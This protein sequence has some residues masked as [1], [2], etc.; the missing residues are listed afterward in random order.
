MKSLSAKLSAICCIFAVAAAFGSSLYAANG[1]AETLEADVVV[2][3]GGSAGFAAAWSA[4]TL[5]SRVILVEKEK[6]LGGTSTLGGVNSWEPVCGATGV[7]RR[8]YARLS[9]MP[10][11]AGVYEFVHHGAWRREGELAFPGAL[12]RVNPA[13]PYEVTLRRHG[14]GIGDEKWFR[15]NCHGVIFEPLAMASVMED[16]LREAGRCQMLLGVACADVVRDGSRVN[17]LVLSDGR[18][19]RA[20]VVVDACGVVCAKMGCELMSGREARSVFGEPGAPDEPSSRKNGATLIYRVTLRT[21]GAE[22]LH[23]L[24]AG[25]PEKCWWG[26][27]GFPSAFCCT[28]PNGDIGVNMLPTMSGEEAARLGAKAAYDECVRRV[29]AHWRWMQMRWPE[30]RRY[31]LKETAPVL[32]LRETVRVRGDYVLTQCDLIAGLEGQRRDDFVAIADHCMDSHGGGGPG[33]EL[34]S[35]YGIPYGCLLPRGG[36]HLQSRPLSTHQFAGCQPGILYR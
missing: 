36:Q 29:H 12:L 18:M 35:P 4:A 19:V 13:L 31:R 20:K 28:Y 34:K 23:A 7:P 6:R 8:V 15:E 1:Q 3:G 22:E 21:D 26:K 25:V 17:A 2:V 32:A 27:F 30:F 10:G 5:G 14:P 9:K 24:P 33:G 16:M 11:A